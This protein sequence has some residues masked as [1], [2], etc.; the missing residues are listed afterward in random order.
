MRSSSLLSALAISAGVVFAI[1]PAAAGP[2]GAPLAAAKST[3]AGS[4]VVLVG[5]YGYRRTRVYYSAPRYY[6]P[7]RAYYYRAPAPAYYAAPPAYYAAPPPVVYYAPPPVYY[8]PPAPVVIVMPS[9]AYAAPA[10][11]YAP[12]AY[13]PPSYY[14]GPGYRDRYYGDGYNDAYYRRW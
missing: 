9:P 12:Q 4:D 8:A 6:A 14:A 3:A 10:Y 2:T 5:G 7:R 13:A 11:G 1:A